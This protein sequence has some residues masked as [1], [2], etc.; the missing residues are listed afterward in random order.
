MN[1]EKEQTELLNKHG[2]FFAFN[3]EQFEESKQEGVEYVST[4]LGMVVPKESALQ[5][6]KE[7]G[8]L[9][10][11]YRKRRLE[12]MGKKNLIH[13]ELANYETQITMDISDA[14]DALEGY[15][16]TREEVQ[17]EMGEYMKYCRDNDLF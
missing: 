2:A 1:L 5:C 4:G 12:E 16:I 9:H 13:Y 11:E 7:L 10:V 15:G 14:V 17:A 3:N 6:M 8:D